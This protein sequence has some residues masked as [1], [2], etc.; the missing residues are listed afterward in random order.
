[1][2]HYDEQYEADRERQA[3]AN[4]PKQVGGV[5]YSS[6]I[7]PDKYIEANKLTFREGNIVKYVTRHRKKNGLQDLLKARDYLNRL[8]SEY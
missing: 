7:D 1:M 3:K 6:T 8:I 2:G 4:K 5:H